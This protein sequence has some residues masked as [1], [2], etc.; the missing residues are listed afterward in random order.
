MRAGIIQLALSREGNAQGNISGTYIKSFQKFLPYLTI[1]HPRNYF[2][3]CRCSATL[4]GTTCTVVLGQKALGW[5]LSHCDPQ[6]PLHTLAQPSAWSSHP[7]CC[8]GAAASTLAWILP[9]ALVHSWCVAA[10]SP[11]CVPSPPS[12]PS[13]LPTLATSPQS[14]L[15]CPVGP[16]GVP[17][18]YVHH[19]LPLT[20]Y[21]GQSDSLQRC[22]WRF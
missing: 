18:P 21:K 22:A 3:Q 17:N 1:F 13:P 14:V 2:C 8:C 12:P 4:M 11:F 5:Q 9:P 7:G 16:P 15:H 6:L 10:V 19:F 20:S